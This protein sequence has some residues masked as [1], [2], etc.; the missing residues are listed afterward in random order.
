MVAEE[1]DL[2]I[3][4]R[5]DVNGFVTGA[6]QVFLNG[7]FGAVCSKAFDA[8]DADV[9]CRQ[10]GFVGGTSIDTAID[11]TVPEHEQQEQVRV[12]YQSRAHT[13][14][15]MT[16]AQALQSQHRNANPM[17]CT[18]MHEHACEVLSI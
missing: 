16:S 15:I 6:L 7:A 11:R 13:C 14:P 9:A 1:G 3:V 18:H 2:R 4:N 17:P 12:P 8:V 10:M 5:V